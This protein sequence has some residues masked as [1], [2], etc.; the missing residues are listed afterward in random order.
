M[1]IS[2]M[3]RF[4]TWMG[5]LAMAIV[6]NGV[7]AEGGVFERFGLYVSAGNL[8]RSSEFYGLVF[9][10]APYVKNDRLAGFDVAGGLFA[11]FASEANRRALV[12][13][14]NTIPY[15]RVKDA[16]IEFERIKRL[17]AKMLDATVVKE[18]PIELFRFA[19]PD[20][21]VIEFFSLTAAR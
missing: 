12:R 10:K 13:G 8:D 18:G 5:V 17:G 2:I 3:N 21:N 20:G 19:D 7:H 14:N 15:I 11:V 1:R 16:N 9:G 6:A 4:Q